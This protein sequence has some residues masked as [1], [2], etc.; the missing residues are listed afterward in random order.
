MVGVLYLHLPPARG[1]GAGSFPFTTLLQHAREAASVGAVGVDGA[2]SSSSKDSGGSGSGSTDAAR[3]AGA[4]GS[5]A[6]PLAGGGTSSSS[7]D[8]ANDDNTSGLP[9]VL[10]R[11][12]LPDALPAGGY[13]G[14]QGSKAAAAAMQQDAEEAAHDDAL[15]AL[16]WGA[17]GDSIT[18]G[19]M[20]ATMVSPGST[21]NP[22]TATES[23]SLDAPVASIAEA[24]QQ[25][26]QQPQPPQLPRDAAWRLRRRLASP[27]FA[28]ALLHELG[29]ALQYVL[30][31]QP[32]P[33]PQ[34][35]QACTAGKV[36]SS[37]STDPAQ[38]SAAQTAQSAEPAASAVAVV[39]PSSGNS[40]VAPPLPPLLRCAARCALDWREAAA[41]VMEL[42][43]RDARG[44]A[45]LGRHWRL[46]CALPPRDAARWEVT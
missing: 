30:T 21:S 10:M 33:M 17:A 44:L 36:T 25:G 35:T 46:G 2:G 42:W 6:G 29:H 4:G 28:K 8:G 26:L 38:G 15:A 9:V 40:V 11:I 41:H 18:A 7:R 27:F 34:Q 16:L 24:D 1:P 22:A 31:Q 39:S 32:Q 19:G 5:A 14:G 23:K 12:N 3:G 45:L 20:T 37:P 13:T 43:G